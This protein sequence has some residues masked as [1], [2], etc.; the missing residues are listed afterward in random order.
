MHLNDQFE[1]QSGSVD[2]HCVSLLW[3]HKRPVHLTWLPACRP[4]PPPLLN[5]LLV[6]DIFI[7]SSTPF[8]RQRAVRRALPP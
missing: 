3:S 6:L 4:S 5:L 8:R 7:K 2:L 1:A